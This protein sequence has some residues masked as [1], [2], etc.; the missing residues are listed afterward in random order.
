MIRKNNK[1]GKKEIHRKR[2]DD[3]KKLLTDNS[4][5]AIKEAY[6]QLRTNLMFSV[7]TSSESQCK[8]FAVTSANPSEGKSI[9]ASNLAISF[10]MMNKK[11][12]LIDCDMRKPNVHHLWIVE[13]DY[14]LSNLL[15]GI[16]KCC[17]HDVEGIPLSILTS[18]KVPPNPSELLSSAK[19]SDVIEK[20][21]QEFDYII[22]DTPPVNQV[23]DALIVSK[24]VDGA[25]LII[26]SGVTQTYEL[27]KA[28]EALLQAGAR[29][30]GI[31][32]NGADIKGGKYSYKGYYGYGEYK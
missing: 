9:T 28:Q 29:I 27:A 23:V 2:I 21:K 5:F 17:L 11:T 8:V 3:R 15:T 18:G 30:S 26:H 16:D 24:I 4:A 6:V 12:L 13:E 10:A 25:V 7:A 14:G 31:V 19:F 20:F 1:T 22:I 32:V